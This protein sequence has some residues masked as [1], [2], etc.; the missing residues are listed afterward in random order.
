[1]VII[2]KARHVSYLFA[3]NVTQHQRSSPHQSNSIGRRLFDNTT[4][5]YLY[6]F[7]T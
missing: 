5:P 7:I 2:D 3:K 4:A 6:S 1:M